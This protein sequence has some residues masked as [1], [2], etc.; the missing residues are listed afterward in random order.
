MA[1]NREIPERN[2]S[3][4][5]T[6]SELKRELMSDKTFNRYY[7]QA[8]TRYAGALDRLMYK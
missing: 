1:S 8:L 4:D 6:Q 5:N 7:Q 3:S 2:K